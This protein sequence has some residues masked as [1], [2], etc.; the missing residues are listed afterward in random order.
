MIDNYL[1]EELVAFAKYNTLAQTAEY[2]N[3]SQPAITR[4]TKKIE[5]E[6][7]LKLFKRTPNKISLNE[8]GKFAAKKAARVLAMNNN[9]VSE[10]QSYD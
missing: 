9:F 6:L 1:L 7:G 2:L 8:T 3:V 4:G 5:E 10:V